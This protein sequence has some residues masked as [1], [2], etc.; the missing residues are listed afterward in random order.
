MFPPLKPPSVRNAGSSATFPTAVPAG[1]PCVPSARSPTPRH[2]IAALT[3]PALRVAISHLSSPAVHPWWHVPLTAKR[4]TLC[5]AGIVPP[6]RK[7]LQMHQKCYLER[8][9]TG[10]IL[11]KTRLALQRSLVQH[12]VPLLIPRVP[13][14]S[15][16]MLLHLGRE[17][18]AP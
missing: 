14:Y 8:C 12:Q 4:S 11:W 1:Y 17:H 7:P 15:P 9:R 6:A 3:L 2:S 18:T 10:W 16:T 13:L 5:G